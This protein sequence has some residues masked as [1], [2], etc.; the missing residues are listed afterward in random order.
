VASLEAGKSILVEGYNLNG[1]FFCQA[2]KTGLKDHQPRYSGPALIVQL[3]GN[4]AHLNPELEKL[5]ASYSRSQVV[6]F[7]REFEWEKTES[8]QPTP[9]ALFGA[10]LDFLKAHELL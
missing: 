10:T 8:W 1:D 2:R 9:P 3:A 6:A 5:A 7:K 4:P